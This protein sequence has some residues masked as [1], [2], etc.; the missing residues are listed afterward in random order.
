M[1]PTTEQT[2]GGSYLLTTRNG[3]YWL[4]ATEWVRLREFY[5]DKRAAIS[6]QADCECAYHLNDTLRSVR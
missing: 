4:A 5:G 2:Y 6:A 1:T 3:A